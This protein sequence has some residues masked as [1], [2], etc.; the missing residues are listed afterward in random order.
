MQLLS[1]A[2]WIPIPIFRSQHAAAYVGVVQER[3]RKSWAESLLES[4]I[5][6]PLDNALSHG[7]IHFGILFHYLFSLFSVT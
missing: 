7:E 5:T 1:L 2:T 4:S 6:H 3:D